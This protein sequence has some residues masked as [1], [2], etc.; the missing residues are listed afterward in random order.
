MK[1]IITEAIIM[2]VARTATIIII[3]I[4]LFDDQRF[5]TDSHT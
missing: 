3:I 1:S 4:N 2:M 5:Q